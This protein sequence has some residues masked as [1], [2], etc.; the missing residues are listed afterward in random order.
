MKVLLVTPDYPPP[1]GGIQTVVQNLERGLNQLGHEAIVLQIDPDDY[2]PEYRDWLPSRISIP[3]LSSL[4]PHLHTYF[5]AVYHQSAKAIAKHNPDVVHAMH[6]RE[7]PAFY[8]A[9]KLDIPTVVSTHALELREKRLA[10][11]AF[12]KAD[13]VHSVS[14]FTASIIQRDHKIHPDSVIPPS[15]DIEHYKEETGSES[16][17]TQ[18]VFS[19]SRLVKRKNIGKI[20]DAWKKV[21][22]TVREGYQLELA[23]TGPAQDSIAERAEGLDDIQLLGRISD[24]EKYRRLRNADLFVLPAGGSGYDVEGFGIVYLEA[25]ATGTPVIGSSVGGVPEAVGDAGLL[26]ENVQDTDELARK[27]GKMLTND[28]VRKRCLNASENRISE[29]DLIPIAE[30]YIELYNSL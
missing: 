21:D 15:I 11:L 26:L 4:K 22:R 29:F 6:I 17:D 8:A 10:S 1:P 20:V 19:I 28:K 14:D 25:Q 3:A 12:D 2:S 16:R 7:W 30:Q 9:Q 24:N 27:I 13:A 18:T 5:N 23:G